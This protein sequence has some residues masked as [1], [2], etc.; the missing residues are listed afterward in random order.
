MSTLTAASPLTQL[1]K[2]PI[3][4]SFDISPRLRALVALAATTMSLAVIVALVRGLTG[5][6]PDHGHTRDMAVVLHVATVLP[7]IPLGGCLLLAPKGTKA[8]KSLG[9]LWVVLMVLTALSA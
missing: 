9:K 5:L 7:A 6:A 8:H 3:K 4:P 1:F 2:A